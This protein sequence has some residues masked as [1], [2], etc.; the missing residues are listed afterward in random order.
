MTILYQP[1]VTL[2]TT[3]AD[4]I[5]DPGFY[6]Y[7]QKKDR[8]TTPVSRPKNFADVILTDIVFGPEVSIGIIHYGLLCFYH[9]S[10]ISFYLYLLQN[11]TSDYKNSLNLSL[12]T[13]ALFQKEYF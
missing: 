9:Y 10:R 8:N 5:L 7:L 13:L 2:D 11:L 6:A 1:T 12:P 4:A 3:T